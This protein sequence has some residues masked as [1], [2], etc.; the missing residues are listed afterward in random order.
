M[1]H[2][3]AVRLTF[4]EQDR[5]DAQAGPD[6][7]ASRALE[8]AVERRAVVGPQHDED[9]QHY[10]VPVAEA[11]ACAITSARA[12]RTA[13]RSACRPASD[14]VPRLARTVSVASRPPGRAGSAA[15]CRGQPCPARA[16]RR[17]AA[18]RSGTRCAA[19][20]AAPP[21]PTA[22]RCRCLGRDAV[23]RAPGG[24]Q[25]VGALARTA[26]DR[27]P[28]ARSAH[29]PPRRGRGAAGP[30]PVIRRGRWTAPSGWPGS[31]RPPR[32][33]RACARGRGPHQRVGIARAHSSPVSWPGLGRALPPCG[34]VGRVAGQAGVRGGQRG[35][36]RAAP[37]HRP[38]RDHQ[39]ACHRPP[40]STRPAR[41][42]AWPGP[43]G[44]A[45]AIS[46]ATGHWSVTASTVGPS[47][48]RTPVT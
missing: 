11:R 47:E 25:V 18:R 23:Q 6:D 34:D 29:V 13:S 30:G 8:S 44:R 24:G 16:P 31:A 3:R 10:P 9:G 7:G 45:L 2:S 28:R 32:P 43:S 27:R 42:T 21:R 40:A 22:S 48:A 12:D 17:S 46:S 38:G 35:A 33:G 36:L 20:R 26:A 41:A 39:Q 37:V 14:D 19:G 15:G 5:R 4:D 1:P